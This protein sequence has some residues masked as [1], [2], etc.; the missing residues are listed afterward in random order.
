MLPNDAL[1]PNLLLA[2]FMVATT[3]VVQNYLTL[4]CANRS[5][6][7]KHGRNLRAGGVK[8]VGRVEGSENTTVMKSDKIICLNV[9]M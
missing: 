5:S 6:V 4:R 1:L 3:K 8:G 7:A 9:L 2:L